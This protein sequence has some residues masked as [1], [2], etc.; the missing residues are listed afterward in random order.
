MHL[1]PPHRIR[2]IKVPAFFD[3][4]SIHPINPPHRHP[5]LRGGRALS[6]P[7][8]WLHR[9]AWVVEGEARTAKG[10]DA[11]FLAIRRSC[12]PSSP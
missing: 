10:N 9:C 8:P 12:S 11:P 6:E 5:I 1:D 2:S 4:P 7:L 3:G